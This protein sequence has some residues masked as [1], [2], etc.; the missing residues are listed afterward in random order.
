[1][2]DYTQK[3]VKPENFITKSFIGTSSS[4]L[5]RTNRFVVGVYPGPGGF[6]FSSNMHETLL[7]NA[8]SVSCPGVDVEFGEGE[9]NGIRRSYMKTRADSD[10]E[11]SFLDTPD[12]T[13]RRF[14]ESWISHG[15]YITGDGRNV[16]RRYITKL[17]GTITVAPL[18]AMGNTYYQDSFSLAFPYSINNIEYN[19]ANDN[20]VH[21]TTVKFKYTIHRIEQTPTSRRG[22]ATGSDYDV[23]SDDQFTD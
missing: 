5:L 8:M 20:E 2:S 22:N 12:M 14:F 1:M 23:P 10:L 19:M 4:G 21:K 17:Y 11:I 9:L 3:F 16:R 18:T 13:I 15:V 6:K 7:W